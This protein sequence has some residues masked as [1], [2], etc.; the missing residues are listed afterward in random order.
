LQGSSGDADMR[1]DLWAWGGVG[2]GES[3]ANGEWR[4]QHG[5]IHITVCKTDSQWEFTV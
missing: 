4:E 1:T 3:G 5:N 2:E